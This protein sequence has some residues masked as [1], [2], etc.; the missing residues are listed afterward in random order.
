[1]TSRFAAR[2]WV[3]AAALLWSSCGLFAKAPLFHDWPDEQRG[4]TLAFWRAL[5]AALFLLPFARQPR[6]NKALVPLCVGFASMNAVYL[7]SIVLTTAANAIW[8]QNLC[9]FWVFLLS[10]FFLHHLP[11][12][13]ELL[14]LLLAMIGVGTILAFESRGQAGLGVALGV[15]SGLAYA[16][17]VVSMWWLRQ[18]NAAFLVAL[19]HALAALTLL[20][21]I[22]Y[23]GQWPSPLQLLVLAGF[24]IW[25]MGLPYFCFVRG[26]RGISS[27]EAV[28]IGLVE[29][30]LMPVWVFLAWDERPA[31]WTV[32]GA[33]LILSGLVLR[34]T[35]IERWSPG[36]AA[37]LDH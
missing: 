24:G 22:L 13:K 1:M 3:L 21:W 5:F 11:D 6:W 27:Q 25:Q 14:P 32:A 34:Y 12:R 4:L 9:P 35:V 20:P 15:A 26:L 23:I 2:L 18:E 19:C 17:V 33:V 16:T 31:P 37:P 36:P 7:S 10:M 30:V 8:L 29:P 28:A